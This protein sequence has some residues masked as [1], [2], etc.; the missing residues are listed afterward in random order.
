MVVVA[1]LVELLVLNVVSNVVVV[2]LLVELLVL[3]VVVVSK[4]VV[5]ERV[6]VYIASHAVTGLRLELLTIT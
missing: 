1:L 2:A 6:V 4:D 5:V 3:N